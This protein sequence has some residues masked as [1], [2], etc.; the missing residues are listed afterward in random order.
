MFAV[1]SITETTAVPSPHPESK[2]YMEIRI[3]NRIY[4][5]TLEDPKSAEYATLRHEVDQ[6][7][8]MCCCW[9]NKRTVVKEPEVIIPP[10]YFN[11]DIPM[12]STHST[13][14]SPN[15]KQ[16]DDREKP[17]KNRTG[18]YVVNK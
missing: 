16:V 10:M 5:T 11:P 4:N 14:D 3:T 8:V 17:P 12:Y 6:L 13:I 18:M 15:G 1:D 2:F 9:P 7:L